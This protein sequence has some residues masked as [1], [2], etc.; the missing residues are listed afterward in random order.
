M[1]LA[2]YLDK[3]KSEG[4]DQTKQEERG[5]QRGRG[6]KTKIEPSRERAK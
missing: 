3:C 4:D 2:D 1:M 5:T 6:K